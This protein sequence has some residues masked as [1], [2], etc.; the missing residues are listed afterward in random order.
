MKLLLVTVILCITSLPAFSQKGLNKNFIGYWASDATSTRTV[1]FKDK[2]DILQMVKWDSSDGEE[3]E[4][5]EMQVVGASIKTKETTRS[6]NWV[7]ECTYTIVDKNKLKC[8][9][10]REDNTTTIFLNRR[11]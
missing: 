8:V 7:I 6:T 1:I 5:N 10:V 9:I 2:E 11:K 4:V 3:I